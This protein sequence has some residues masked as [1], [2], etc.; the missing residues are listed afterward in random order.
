MI[1]SL[2]SIELGNPKHVLGWASSLLNPY[3]PAEISTDVAQPIARKE[4]PLIWFAGTVV[5]LWFVRIT[6]QDA[7]LYGQLGAMSIFFESLRET[8]PP[9]IGAVVVYA[10][11]RHVFRLRFDYASTRLSLVLAGIAAVFYVGGICV[12]GYLL[13]DL[14]RTTPWL[15]PL[16][17]AGPAFLAVPTDR[18]VARYAAASRDCNSRSDS[19]ESVLIKID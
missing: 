15:V 10:A 18:L 4:A 14:A 11:M 5:A 1:P 6:F 7:Y 8:G 19:S 3:E 16:L 2:R 9:A 17:L 13:S 12:A